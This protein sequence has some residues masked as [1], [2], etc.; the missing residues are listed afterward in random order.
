MKYLIVGL[1]NIGKEYEDT[2]HNIGFSVLNAWAKEDSA[3]WS[4]EKHAYVT[5]VSN[6]GRKFVLIKPTTYM[7]L[8][9][10]AVNY[11]MQQEKIKVENVLIIVDDLALSF[12][13]IRLK[14]K[15]S[16]AG[17]NGLAN[18]AETLGH[19]NYPRLRFGIGAEYS[20]GKQ[21]DYV[22]GKWSKDEALDLPERIDTMIQLSKSFGS[23]GLARTMN[24]F[25]GK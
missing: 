4:F 21:I 7:N 16:D 20:K 13:A 10:K 1:G 8:S 15:G 9:G 11:W 17:H 14:A 18:I 2:R 23:I 12:G 6:K 3:E 24:L 25:N 5:E 19:T 22:L